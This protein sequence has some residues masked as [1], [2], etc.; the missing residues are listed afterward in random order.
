MKW[1]D[2]S[3]YIT[4]KVA[5]QNIKSYLG[6]SEID[7]FMRCELAPY[8]TYILNYISRRLV[9]LPEDSG[10]K[11][12]IQEVFTIREEGETKIIYGAVD[13]LRAELGIDSGDIYVDDCEIPYN[14]DRFIYSWSN[15]M[16]A[17]L[18]RIK[19]Q[20]SGLLSQT[21]DNNC[22]PCGGD[23]CYPGQTTKDYESWTSAVYPEDEEYSYYNFKESTSTEWRVN[24][25]TPECTKCLRRTT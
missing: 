6:L 9:L 15:V 10:I 17:L 24:N 5:L 11:E 25:D 7:Y 13:E 12:Y 8:I 2:K 18:V 3:G 16:T 21:S 4:Y 20:Y 19:F 22:C 23:T 1:N 14:E